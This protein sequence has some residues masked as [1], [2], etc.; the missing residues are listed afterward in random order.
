MVDVFL[1]FL[2]WYGGATLYLA[3]KTFAKPWMFISLRAKKKTRRVS[4]RKMRH[5]RVGN[6]VSMTHRDGLCREGLSHSTNLLHYISFRKRAISHHGPSRSFIM[7]II[8]VCAEYRPHFKGGAEPLGT[9][10]CRTS[11]TH[12]MVV[13][14]SRRRRR[15]V[16]PGL[17]RFS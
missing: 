12:F 3:S 15:G 10:E 5:V 16:A 17:L 11:K 1:V 13:R 7:P 2:F 9:Y 8:A 14:W 4:T 6:Y